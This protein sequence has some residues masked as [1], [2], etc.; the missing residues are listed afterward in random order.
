[1]IEV[2]SWIEDNHSGGGSEKLGSVDSGRKYSK[3]KC[4]DK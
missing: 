4:I 1:M 2:P 3:S